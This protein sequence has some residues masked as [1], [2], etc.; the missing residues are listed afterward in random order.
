MWNLFN[1]QILYVSRLP[2]VMAR[3]GWLPKIF[4]RVS[5]SAAPNAAILA[6]SGLAIIFAAL[7]FGS[8]A[9]I[10]CLLY[11]GALVLEYLALIVLR[12]RR[13]DAHRTFRVPG[14]WLGLSYVCLV[15]F[16]AS[17]LV[18]MTT[19]REWRSFPGQIAVVAALVI[20]GVTLYLVRRKTALLST[21]SAADGRL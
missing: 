20:T 21:G 4:G 2:L 6:I 7:S 16:A 9:L 13:P 3:D 15:P 1:S 17:A 18:V 12:I 14:G 19:L 10:Q 11:T 5:D 8:L